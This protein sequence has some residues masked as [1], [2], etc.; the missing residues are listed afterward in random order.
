[1]QFSLIFDKLFR[2][3]GPQGWW[4]ADTPFEMMIG[5]ILV[6]NTNWRNV[7]KA[8]QKLK[9]FLQPE[10]I[11]QMPMDKLADLIRSSGF[12]NIKAKR[13]KAFMAWFKKYNFDVTVIRKLSKEQLRHELL[14]INGIGNETADVILL[15][16]FEKPIFVV[17]AY[18]RRIFF[19]MGY[20]MPISYDG[21]RKE[22][23]VE[24]QGD[25]TVYNEFHALLVVHAKEHCKVKPICEGCPL[26]TSCERRLVESR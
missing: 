18:T 19:R 7:D 4:P 1:M 14:R 10:V 5:S 24:L 12:Y 15:Y 25:L 13:I 2:H 17:D 26:Y 6:Q 23:E 3:Y 9:P 11:E 21:F 8:L 22:V 20:D 16:A